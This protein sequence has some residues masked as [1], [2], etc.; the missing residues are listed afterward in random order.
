[1]RDSHVE[2]LRYRLKT[3][4]TTTYKNPPVVEVSC[5][6]F[7]CYLNDGVLTCYMQ[8]HYTTIEEARRVVENFIRSWEIKAALE[9]GRE[10]M[11]FDFEYSHVIDRN[12]PPPGSSEFVH[13]SAS[14]VVKFTGSAISILY[15]T[16][17]K[18]PDPPTIFTITPDVETLWQRYNN[19]LDGKEPLPSMAY[20]CLTLIE[21]KAGGK[22]KRKS[23]AKL[24]LIDKQILE[25]LGELTA[26]KG[27]TETARKVP[28]EGSITAL[29]EKEKKWIEAVVKIFIQ[30]M[31][32]LANIQKAKLITM[33]DLPKI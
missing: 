9:L 32:E 5:D 14:G 15:I 25:K 29:N 33:T 16:R 1:M 18:Y 12:P 20:F 17:S 22:K 27:N 21:N 11:K 4:A 28:K 26:N 3:S 23:A 13:V 31:G 24:F 6:E 10:E 7:K 19:Y 2:S 8:E 30:R